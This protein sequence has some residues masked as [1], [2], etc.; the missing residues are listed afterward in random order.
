VLTTQDNGVGFDV[1]T[2]SHYVAEAHIGLL[3]Q[4]ERV[5]A[6]GGR[7]DLISSPGAGTT[8]TVTMPPTIRAQ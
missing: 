4:R 1:N 6:A 7:L 5:E 2:I 3:S 8:I